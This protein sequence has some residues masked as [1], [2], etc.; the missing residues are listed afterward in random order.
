MTDRNQRA[1]HDDVTASAVLRSDTRTANLCVRVLLLQQRSAGP[2]LLGFP[3]PASWTLL[4]GFPAIGV[5]NL[6]G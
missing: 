4:H 5:P 1:G 3:R 2:F 6:F